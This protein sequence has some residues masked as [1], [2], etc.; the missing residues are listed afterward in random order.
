MKNY[1]FALGLESE[2]I[3]LQETKA[4]LASEFEEKRKALE[5]R[6]KVEIGKL[7]EI[8]SRYQSKKA[9]IQAYSELRAMG[10][11]GSRIMSWH[12]LILDNGLDFGVLESELKKQGDLRTLEE[13][14]SNKIKELQDQERLLASSVSGLTE[15]KRILESSISSIKE[16]AIKRA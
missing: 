5:S 1:D 14:T 7:S 12:Q 13:E 16:G 6:E 15:Q 2:V 3:R 8:E 11:E 9:E 4:S 10:I